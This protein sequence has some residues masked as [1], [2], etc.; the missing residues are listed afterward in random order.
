MRDKLY[1]PNRKGD[2]DGE[3]IDSSEGYVTDE[4]N[5]RR[6]HFA[7]C[8]AP[9]TFAP[10]SFKPAIFRGLITFEYIRGIEKDVHGMNKLM[11][12][13]S[14][15]IRLCWLAPLLDVMGTETDWN[16]GGKWR[17]IGDAEMLY[18]RA[19]CKGKPYC[20]L[21]NTDF[22]KFPHEYVEKF[23][24]RSLAYGMFPGFFSADASTKTYF[25]QPALYNRDRPLFKKYIPLCRKVAEAF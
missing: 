1:G 14:T 19:L 17:P 24:K 4:L 8:E 7:G 18:R 5:F 3:Y 10:G 9:L 21:M 22:E 25:S 15:P 20:F 12:A 23:M 6:D 2:L 16:H 13:N 11:M